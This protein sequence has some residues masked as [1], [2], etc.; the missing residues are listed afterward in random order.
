MDDGGQEEWLRDR[1]DFRVYPLGRALR[2]TYSA[3]NHDTLSSDVTGLMIDLSR[4]PYE[5]AIAT[6]P[7]RPGV[8]PPAQPSA[9][10]LRPSILLRLGEL[11]G[12]R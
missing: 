6:T 8:E 7:A 10:A 9:S 3:D 11:F 5:P 4:V 2:D 1:Q 12:R